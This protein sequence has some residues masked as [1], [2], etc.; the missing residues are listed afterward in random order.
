MARGCHGPTGKGDGPAATA[1][2]PKP[3]NFTGGAFKF[4]TD[5]DG[6]TGTDADLLNLDS[7]VDRSILKL[8]D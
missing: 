3:R 7:S 4:D 6:K 8:S 1:L 2:D 5:G